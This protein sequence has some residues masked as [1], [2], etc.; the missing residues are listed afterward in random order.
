MTAVTHTSLLSYH[1][2]TEDL[3]LPSERKREEEKEEGEKEKGI[4][5]LK[6]S[7]HTYRRTLKTGRKLTFVTVHQHILKI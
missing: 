7:K 4:V 1:R 6:I 3:F 5:A 2:H